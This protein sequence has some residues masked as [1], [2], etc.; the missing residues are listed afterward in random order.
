MR[1][2]G[3]DY[4][5]ITTTFA[6]GTFN[7]PNPITATTEIPLGDPDSLDLLLAE[8]DAEYLLLDLRESPPGWISHPHPVR[9]MQNVGAPPQYKLA[10]AFDLVV[11]VKEL[12]SATPY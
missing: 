5:A 8:T 9:P 2:A 12:H 4:L 1:L 11:H 7:P 10:E 6:A 3:P